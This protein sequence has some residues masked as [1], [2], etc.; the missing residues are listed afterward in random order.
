MGM[1][2]FGIR[3]VGITA[4]A[5]AVGLVAGIAMSEIVGIVGR[6]LFDRAVGVKYLAICV[7]VGCAAAVL[8]GGLWAHR[9]LRKMSQRGPRRPSQRGRP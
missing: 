4:L 5:A 2:A 3:M 1:S 6:L 8:F 7:A 9:G